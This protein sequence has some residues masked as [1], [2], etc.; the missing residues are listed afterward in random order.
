[1]IEQQKKLNNTTRIP[2]V[3]V[4]LAQHSQPKSVFSFARK[5]ENKFNVFNKSSEIDSESL[6]KKSVE[7]DVSPTFNGAEKSK[8]ESI[9]DSLHH[10][11]VSIFNDFKHIST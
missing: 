1:M 11:E 5:E 7:S 2:T 3:S 9:L 4:D 6:N 8:R 10:N